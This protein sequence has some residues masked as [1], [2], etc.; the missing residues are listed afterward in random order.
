VQIIFLGDFRMAVAYHP[1][2][3]VSTNY[4]LLFYSATR[5]VKTLFIRTTSALSS[6][7]QT[8]NRTLYSTPTKI[9]KAKRNNA[10]TGKARFKDDFNTN[11]PQRR[12]KRFPLQRRGS[13]QLVANSL[14]HR[15]GSNYSSFYCRRLVYLL[16][17]S[18]GKEVETVCYTWKPV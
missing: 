17:L 4:P 13:E 18:E 7:I 8:S 11:T 9:I 2:S 14:D 15:C 12:R 3:S 1:Y 16:D 5:H 6:Q 10:T